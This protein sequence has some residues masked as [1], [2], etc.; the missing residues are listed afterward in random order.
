MVKNSSQKLTIWSCFGILNVHSYE[1]C[2][3]QEYS[4]CIKFFLS[5]D[6]QYKSK[7][8][9]F[10]QNNLGNVI[11]FPFSEAMSRIQLYASV[12][13]CILSSVPLRSWL[14]DIKKNIVY[15]KNHCL[16]HTVLCASWQHKAM[17][18]PFQRHI[19][20]FCHLKKALNGPLS[21]VSNPW[22]PAICFLFIPFQIF[23][24][25]TLMQSDHM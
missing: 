6:L 1:K 11:L 8:T 21:T 18:A 5:S 19:E 4:V 16:L 10:S 24:N 22:H 17:Y 14:I 13:V 20:L 12:T 7:N 2:Y 3:Q 9:I 23:W 25:V 15:S